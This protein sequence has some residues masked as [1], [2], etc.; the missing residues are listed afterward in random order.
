VMYRRH[1]SLE[2]RIDHVGHLGSTLEVVTRLPP[3]REKSNNTAGDKLRRR[4][5]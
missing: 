5:E 1:G 4:L 3:Y 2:Q